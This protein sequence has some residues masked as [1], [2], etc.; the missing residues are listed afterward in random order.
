VDRRVAARIEQSGIVAISG[1]DGGLRKQEFT[2]WEQGVQFVQRLDPKDRFIAFGLHVP[3][4]V[5]QKLFP[6]AQSQ[7]FKER[8]ANFVYV[9]DAL[10]RRL[11]IREDD[12]KVDIIWR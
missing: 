7:H 9:S 3:G 12:L 8:L 2:D 4:A 1:S 11:E 6:K 10:S 5:L